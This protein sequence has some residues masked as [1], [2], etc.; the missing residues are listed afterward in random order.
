MAAVELN[1]PATGIVVLGASNVSRGLPRLVAAVR[2]RAGT[3]LDL[4]VAA[5]HGRSYGAN[6]RVA[7]RRLP[8]ILASGL[9]RALDREAATAPGPTGAL[10]TDIGNDLLYGFAVSQV[11]AWVRES[12]RRL[13]ARGMRIAITRLPLASIE[14]VGP[15]RYRALRTLYVPGCRLSL[16]DLVTAAGDL[17]A[18]VIEI[19][20]DHGATLIEQPG[21]WYGLDAIHVRRRRLAELWHAAGDAWGLPE[22]RSSG[23][24]T[25]ADWMLLGTRAP[26]VRSLARVPRFT[27][28]PCVRRDDLRLWLY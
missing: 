6:S 14:R 7:L 25:F 26:E 18:A 16:A 19:A 15:F 9:W 5:G 3:P 27:P 23:G 12:V 10:V 21:A 17:D 28:Q 4:L 2:E 24:A 11:A 20:R 13:A 22:A 8:S 1:G